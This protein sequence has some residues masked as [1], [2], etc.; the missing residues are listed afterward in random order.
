[1]FFFLP[2]SNELAKQHIKVCV[3]DVFWLIIEFEEECEGMCMYFV[4]PVIMLD[5]V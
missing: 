1:M 2:E 5:I 3:F 4:I